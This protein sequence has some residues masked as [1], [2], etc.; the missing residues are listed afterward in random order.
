MIIEK[1]RELVRIF[2][3]WGGFYLNICVFNF[4]VDCKTLLTHNTDCRKEMMRLYVLSKTIACKLVL[5]SSDEEVPAN[6]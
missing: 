4:H 6:G 1:A 2:I 5:L 3:F